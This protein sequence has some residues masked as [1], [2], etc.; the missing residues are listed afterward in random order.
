MSSGGKGGSQSTQ[1]ALPDWA[2]SA[3]QTAVE[4]GQAA[5]QVGYVPY[6]GP[7][8]AA[9]TPDQEAAFAATNQAASAFGMP[10]SSGAGLPEAQTF[11]DGTQGYSS[12]SLYEQALDQLRETNPAQYAAIQGFTMDPVNGLL[13]QP[14]AQPS[15]QSA[16]G[17]YVRPEIDRDRDRDAIRQGRF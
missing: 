13:S 1:V 15:A 17:Q 2:S 12:Y 16:S 4:Q 8:V 11:S 6:M 9:M 10:T 5:G 3:A 14:Q 7:D